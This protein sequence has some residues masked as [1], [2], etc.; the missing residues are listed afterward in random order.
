VGSAPK[1]LLLAMVLHAKSFDFL[2]G[3]LKLGLK[4]MGCP[5]HR[6]LVLGIILVYSIGPKEG[7]SGWVLVKGVFP[8]YRGPWSAHGRAGDQLCG[9][10]GESVQW[11]F[12]SEVIKCGFDGSSKMTGREGGRW[13]RDLERR[14]LGD[15]RGCAVH[16]SRP[17]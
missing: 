16:E 14:G 11:W 8:F 17:H 13:F 4:Y 2:R 12:L 1:S 10:E 5:N 7:F 9:K 6:P 3:P 15:R